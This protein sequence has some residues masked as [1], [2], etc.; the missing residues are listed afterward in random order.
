MLC[1]IF[2]G[3]LE[4]ITYSEY[5]INTVKTLVY[6]TNLVLLRKRSGC[7]FS[8]VSK[9]CSKRTLILTKNY[10]YERACKKR[11]VNGA[12]YSQKT[13]TPSAVQT[14]FKVQAEVCTQL[15]RR[16]ENAN[17]VLKTAQSLHE[18]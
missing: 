3:K 14:L 16:S 11:V 12:D 2:A 18:V 9:S 1:A 5:E 7:R 8:R 4:A 15:A 17:F 10:K 6:C 13:H